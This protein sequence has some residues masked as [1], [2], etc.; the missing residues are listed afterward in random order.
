MDSLLEVYCDFDGTVTIGDTT[1]VLLERLA[2]PAWKEIEERWERGEIGS[3]ECMALQVP[4]IAGGWKAMTQV[5]DTVK[6]DPS[7]AGF[8]KWCRSKDIP[9]RIVSDG[10]DR[11]IYYLLAKAGIKVDFVWANHLME[12]ADGSLTLLSPHASGPK[13]C[14]SGVCKCQIVAAARPNPVKVVIGDG[15][16][17]FCWSGQAD[18]LFAKSKLLTYC[19][20]NN[21]SCI[22]YEDF[23]S[24]RHNLEER[25]AAAERPVMHRMP[26]FA[27]AT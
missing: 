11:V 5:L 27:L 10:I 15:R 17:D 19:H 22:A 6:I 21:M 25:L 23:T 16:S 4:L 20:Q 3:R 2:D 7:F 26:S 9:L 14:N 24:I 18:L 8:A 12:A 13:S 1:D